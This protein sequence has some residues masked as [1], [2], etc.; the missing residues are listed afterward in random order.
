MSRSFKT[1]LDITKIYIGKVA[2]LDAKF[3]RLQWGNFPQGSNLAF[4]MS[5]ER[6]CGNCGN[7]EILSS[8]RNLVEASRV[9]GAETT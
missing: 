3:S 9:L 8:A 7:L 1:K 4:E 6:H 5:V 2:D